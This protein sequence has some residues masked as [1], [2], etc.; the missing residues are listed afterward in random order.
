MNHRVLVT[1]GEQFFRFRSYTPIPIFIVMLFCDWHEW[2]LDSVIW[3]IGITL[4]IV[5]ESLRLWTSRYIGKFSRT[6]K[7]KGRVLIEEGPYALMRN[8]LYCGNL[9]ILTGFAFASELVWL[10]PII[11]TSFFLQYYFIIRW[12]E[13]I[14]LDYFHHDAQ[15]YLQQVPRWVPQWQ[16]IRNLSHVSMQ[17]R[18]PWKDV[19]YRERRT[20]QFLLVMTSL[21]VFKDFYMAGC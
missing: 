1:L 6:R 17:P 10:I 9:L 11:I 3:P 19:L 21:L 14:L 18:H 4:V 20:L 5:G 16:S 8:P 7:R 12:E 15:R 13:E 2:E